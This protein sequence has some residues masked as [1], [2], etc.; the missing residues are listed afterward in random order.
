MLIKAALTPSGTRLAAGIGWSALVLGLGALSITLWAVG[1][2]AVHRDV[3]AALV[4]EYEHWLTGP[5]TEADR[6]NALD[7]IGT[8]RSSVAPSPFAPGRRWVTLAD[9]S[10]RE[11]SLRR[12]VRN[13]G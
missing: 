5:I 10:A 4:D 11:A 1:R 8:L 12:T 3:I 7:A 9:L 13:G 2:G 6:D